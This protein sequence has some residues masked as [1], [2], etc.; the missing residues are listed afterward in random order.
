ME[1]QST[2]T[3]GSKLS[4]HESGPIGKVLDSSLTYAL[5]WDTNDCDYDLSWNTGVTGSIS[6]VGLGEVD[7]SYVGFCS[8][9]G[10]IGDTVTCSYDTNY[11]VHFSLRVDVTEL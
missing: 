10:S 5:Y 9:G 4:W 3:I 11:P 1:W 8:D 6:L 7:T 2:Q